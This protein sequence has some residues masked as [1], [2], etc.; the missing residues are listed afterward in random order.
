MRRGRGRG[1]G[2]V[3]RGWSDETDPPLE[4]KQEPSREREDEGD[5]DGGWDATMNPDL[6][7][8]SVTSFN[9]HNVSSVGPIMLIL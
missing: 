2:G 8:S 1:G 3:G 7:S 6:V 5:W 9:S 4:L